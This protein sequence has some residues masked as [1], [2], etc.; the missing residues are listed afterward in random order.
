MLLM[1]V[2]QVDKWR[3]PLVSIAP[4]RRLEVVEV[5]RILELGK[6]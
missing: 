5:S 3:A 2:W 6:G 1:F 4:Q